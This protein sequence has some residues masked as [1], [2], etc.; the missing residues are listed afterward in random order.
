MKWR[1]ISHCPSLVDENGYFHART[2]NRE[3]DHGMDFASCGYKLED[4]ERELRAQI[5]LAIK[6]IRSVTHISSHMGASNATPELREIAERLANE[7]GLASDETQ[8]LM[9]FNAF[10]GADD[11]AD[12]P[13]ALARNLERLAPGNYLV[14]E[15]PG[16][17]SSEMRA[18]GHTGYWNVAQERA[19]VTEALTSPRVR[20]VVQRRHIQLISYADLRKKG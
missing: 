18:T 9:H 3:D 5:E 8:G 7:F 15:H 12:R 20:E 19:A 11:T 17:D 10:E 13:A 1:P 16:L 14:I 6:H 4:A 2:T